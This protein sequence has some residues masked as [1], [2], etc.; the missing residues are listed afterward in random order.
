MIANT[1][2]YSGE[3]I[4]CIGFDFVVQLTIERS[5]LSVHLNTSAKFNVDH[6]CS[7]GVVQLSHTIATRH[8]YR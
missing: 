8:P 7:S 4:F 6:E 1:I 3:K 2:L 5:F